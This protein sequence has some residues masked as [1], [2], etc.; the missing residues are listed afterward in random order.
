M[1]V[2]SSLRRNDEDSMINIDIAL[3]D[4]SARHP[5]NPRK[6]RWDDSKSGS[7]Q[8]GRNWKWD[9]RDEHWRLEEP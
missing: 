6:S 4:P 9:P 3:Y 7:P 2:S 8:A 1:M 5:R